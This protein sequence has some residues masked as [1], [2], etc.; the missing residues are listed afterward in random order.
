MQPSCRADH[1]LLGF[2]LRLHQPLVVGVPQ[3]EAPVDDG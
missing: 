3:D 2:V 1:V